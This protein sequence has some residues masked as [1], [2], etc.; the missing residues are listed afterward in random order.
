MDDLRS[1]IMVQITG[2]RI[3][4]NPQISTFRFICPTINKETKVGEFWCISSIPGL[5]YK[6]FQFEDLH[7]H[8]LIHERNVAVLKAQ[9]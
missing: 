4:I 6:E 1:W 3:I 8:P 7:N 2:T 9:L 5:I